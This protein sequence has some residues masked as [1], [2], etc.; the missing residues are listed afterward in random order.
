MAEGSA[1]SFFGKLRAL[2]LPTADYAIFGSGPLAVRGL[3]EEVHDLDVVARGAAWEQAKGLGKVRIA[4]EGDPVV[5]LE[6]GVI[7]VFGGWLGW[8]IDM[9][10]DNAQIIDGLPFASLE[11]VLAFKLSL[12]RPKDVAHARLIEG[13]LRG[14]S[15]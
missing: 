15:S 8:D 5:W 13:Y 7:E 10:I 1:L 11:D 2:D 9:L 6:G 4:P 3:I 14:G 12:G